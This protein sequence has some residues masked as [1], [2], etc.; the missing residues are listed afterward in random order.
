MKIRNESDI[1][2]EFVKSLLEK[3]LAIKYIYLAT[4]VLFLGMA[5]LFN[6][7]SPK[8]YKLNST[9]GP[10]ENTRSSTLASNDMFRGSG[11]SY[12]TSRNL[13]DAIN[14]LNSFALISKTINN[15]NLEISYY[16]ASSPLFNQYTEIYLNSPV[17]VNI[18]KS[19]VQTLDAKFKVTI[20]DN[21]SFRLTASGKKATFYNYIDNEIVAENCNILVDTICKFNET[22]TSN[23]FKFSVTPNSVFFAEAL[24]NKKPSYFELYHPEALAKSYLANFKFEPVSWLASIIDIQFTGSNLRKSITFLNSYVNIFLEDNLDKKNKMAVNT[25]NY[26]DNQISK[27]SDSLIKSESNLRNFRSDNQVMDLSFQGQRTYEQ[28]TQIETERT[29]LELQSRYYNYV[30]NYFKTNQDISGVTPPSSANINDPILNKLFTDILALN[31]EKS[32]I[33]GSNE[34]NL[35][36]VQIDNKIKVQK[37]TI[38]DNI[39]NN[40]NTINLTLNEL[41]YKA[42]KLTKELAAIPKK[43]MNMVNIQRKFDL[44]NTIYTYLLQ[45]RTESAITLSS[46]FPDYEVLEPAREITSVT[47]KPKKLLNYLIS[48][49]LSLLIPTMYVF[50]KFFFNDRISS[51]Y[52][53][54]H[55][56]DKSVFGI[57]YRNNKK[58]EA[59]VAQSPGSAISESF[60]NLRGSILLKLKTEQLKV[61]LVTSSQPQD[62]KSFISFNLAASIASVGYKTIIV[63]CDLRR[64]VLHSKFQKEN[65]LGISNYITKTSTEDEIIQ[66]TSIEN[67]SFIAAG[68]VLPN[69]SELISSGV[70][71]DLIDYLKSKFEYIIIDTPPIGLVSDSIQLMK[72]SSQVLVVSRIDFTKKEILTNTVASLKSNKIDNFE[73]VI[74]NVDLERSPYSSYKSYYTKE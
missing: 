28:M 17:I 15:L 10:L 30:L 53:V 7:Y 57:I 4:I 36:S 37:Q 14:S 51:I 12:N 74:N 61:I 27:M 18:D 34:R 48:I 35:F 24:K 68:P 19:H 54:E 21:T 9:I 42:E 32:T 3:M 43:E 11:T 39:T 1:A 41:N 56:T 20:L 64:P 46:N 45:K 66:N 13:E 72:Y 38:I 71:D 40:L 26:I 63:D 73:V 50:V 49:F 47:V 52:D 31:S 60:R 65:S 16:M 55:L 25:I 23:Y 5:F 8:V 2:I 62:G 22:I 70:L 59:V 33:S 44:N 58:Y 29:N 67:L 6:K 69:P